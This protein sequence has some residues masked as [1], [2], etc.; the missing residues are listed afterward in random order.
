MQDAGSLSLEG[1]GHN[2]NEN[3]QAP[4]QLIFPV[5]GISG[6]SPASC[7]FDI[8]N[9]KCDSSEAQTWAGLFLFGGKLE[10]IRI[11]LI[12]VNTAAPFK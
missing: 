6:G 11:T 9:I 10:A 5:E 3:N 12:K 4:S 7:L 2:E 1:H 8:C